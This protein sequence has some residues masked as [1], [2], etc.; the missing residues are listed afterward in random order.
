MK[1]KTRAAA[2]KVNVLAFATNNMPWR[3]AVAM[4]DA[5]R[6]TAPL[7]LRYIVRINAPARATD[8]L[9]TSSTALIK[10]SWPLGVMAPATSLPTWCFITPVVGSAPLI[11]LS[12]LIRSRAASARAPS[13]LLAI[14]D[15]TLPVGA[16]LPLVEM[17][18]RF[19]IVPVV[20]SKLVKI[21][22]TDLI[23]DPAAETIPA[24]DCP[25]LRASD[26]LGFSEP[27]W[28]THA[29]LSSAAAVDRMPE[30]RF[31]TCLASDPAVDTLPSAFFCGC[32]AR[33]PDVEALPLAD[34]FMNFD[35]NPVGRIALASF[36]S[37]ER[38]DILP[39][40]DTLPDGLNCG[41]RASEDDDDR[42]PSPR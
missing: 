32:R 39:A 23:I 28:L 18:A 24:K 27:L 33:A 16:A 29:D 1:V 15:F 9:K 26:P 36:S 7:M 4:R 13:I 2:A 21:A 12:A 37:T 5:D 8:A 25:A 6:A 22:S 41:C 38:A 31:C 19:R 10:E 40:G 35:S 14:D 42:L 20:E 17:F 30:T 34:V 3:S 11:A